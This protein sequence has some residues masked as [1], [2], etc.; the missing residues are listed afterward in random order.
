MDLRFITE[1]AACRLRKSVDRKK[2]KQMKN[3]VPNTKSE[4]LMA[5][6]LAA[7]GAAKFGPAIALV[8]NDE[9]TIKET[10]SALLVAQT[11]SE[12]GKVVLDTRRTELQ[13]QTEL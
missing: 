13:T 9:K 8:H 3:I 10:S 5:C 2:T 6:E 4:L 11:A 1:T 7:R 12:Q